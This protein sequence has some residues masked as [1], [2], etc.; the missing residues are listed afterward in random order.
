MARLFGREWYLSVGSL[1]LTDLDLAFKVTRSVRREP[2]LAEIRIWNLSPETRAAIDRDQIVVLRAGYE[3]PPTLFRGE[4]RDVRTERDGQADFVTVVQARDGGRAYNDARMS[5]AYAPGTPALRVLRDAVAALEIGEGNLADFA[6]A[7][8]LRTGSDGFADGYVA[9]GPARR[10]LDALAR[11]AGLR[12][13]VQNG[14]LQLME[15]GRPLQ[16]RAVVLAADSGLVESPTWNEGR[17]R[18]TVTAKSLIQPGIEPGR[19]V[20]LESALITGDFEVRAIEYVGDTRGNDW[21]AT[22]ELRPVG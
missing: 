16:R 5:R 20:V 4:I 13:S 2:N 8:A 12:W 10:V 7:Y 3:D 21:I 22:M 11:G 1:D 6:S 14:A 9:A 15:Q 19:I 17:R 18:R